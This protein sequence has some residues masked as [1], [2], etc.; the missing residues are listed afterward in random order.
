M[1]MSCFSFFQKS[2]PFCNIEDSIIS[3]EPLPELRP[4]VSLL[5][6]EPGRNPS[7]EGQ[8]LK[9]VSQPRIPRLFSGTTRT[10]LLNSPFPPPPGFEKKISKDLDLYF[11]HLGQA[12][13]HLQL[14]HGSRGMIPTQVLNGQ[15]PSEC[16]VRRESFPQF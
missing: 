1:K 13:N 11:G 4:L 2:E 7:I 14:F 9:S 3:P 8:M 12:Q 5:P 10:M 6:V 15:L 16:Q